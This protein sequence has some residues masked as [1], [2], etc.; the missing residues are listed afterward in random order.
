MFSQLFHS[1]GHA[2]QTHSCKH[3]NTHTHAL[4]GCLYHSIGVSTLCYPLKMPLVKTPIYL[5]F[6]FVFLC[7]SFS[8]LPPF[9]LSPSLSPASSL[10]SPLSL[11]SHFLFTSAKIDFLSHY[12]KQPSAVLSNIVSIAY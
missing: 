4:F 8:L 10:L 9:P 3:I 2:V 6:V 5:S 12:F 11:A 7:F 1:C